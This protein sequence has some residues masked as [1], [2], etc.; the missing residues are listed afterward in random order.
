MGMM[1]T[2]RNEAVNG[3]WRKVLFQDRSVAQLGSASGLGPE[4]RGFESLHSDQ[5]L[6]VFYA[7]CFMGVKKRCT[8]SQFF[9]RLYRM[10][11]QEQTT[12]DGSMR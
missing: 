9:E 7:P 10:Y 5:F 4:G 3:Y 8:T 6:N 12:T 1:R 11:R 2:S